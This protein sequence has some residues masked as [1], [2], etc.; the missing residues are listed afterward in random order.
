MATMSETETTLLRAID[1]YYSAHGTC[2]ATYQLCNCTAG[3]LYVCGTLLRALEA[4]S[5]LERIK[6]QR[7]GWH[8]TE[9]GR[10]AIGGG[11]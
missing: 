3:D 7:W 8:L 4:R 9:T 6:D 5:Y 2:P 1:R 10:A 11:L